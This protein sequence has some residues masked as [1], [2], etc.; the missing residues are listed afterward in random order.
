MILPG[1][2]TNKMCVKLAHTESG[3]SKICI[4]TGKLET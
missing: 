3:E 2:E 1:M 4:W